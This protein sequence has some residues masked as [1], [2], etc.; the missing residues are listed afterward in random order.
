MPGMQTCLQG[1]TS[2]SSR[3][4]SDE[5]SAGV[6]RYDNGRRQ[7]D[8]TACCTNNEIGTKIRRQPSGARPV[9]L[10]ALHHVGF[11][12]DKHHSK[13]SI[14][15]QA[16]RQEGAG[17]GHVD[18]CCCRRPSRARVTLARDELSPEETTRDD[19]LRHH[20]GGFDAV[21]VNGLFFV[22]HVIHWTRVTATLGRL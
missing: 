1:T 12:H 5:E 20:G 17:S 3:I 10:P 16:R 18:C 21:V 8:D 13:E 14:T 6:H 19:V 9:H 11:R 4:Y 22:E 15:R 2:T 7:A